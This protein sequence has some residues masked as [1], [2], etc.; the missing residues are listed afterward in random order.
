MKNV[1]EFRKYS[2]K[3]SSKTFDVYSSESLF[4][5][6]TVKG[7]GVQLTSMLD[8]PRLVTN[9]VTMCDPDVRSSLYSNISIVGGNSYFLGLV[10]R[11]HRELSQILPPAMRMKVHIPPSLSER[12]FSSWIGGSIL[13]SLG[14]FHQM[15]I[16]KQEYDE[17]GKFIIDRKC[18]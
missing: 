16:S 5:P 7:G 14:S 18:P 9:S 13:A 17:S 11:L 8:L 3:I 12:R 2:Q 15:W 1:T 6:S 10:E 4:S